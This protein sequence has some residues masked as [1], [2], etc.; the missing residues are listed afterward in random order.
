MRRKAD[1][2]EVLRVAPVSVVFQHH[3]K[4][5]E[6]PRP[7]DRVVLAVRFLDGDRVGGTETVVVRG[8][9]QTTEVLGFVRHVEVQQVLEAQTD[10]RVPGGV[11]QSGAV[12]TAP[13]RR[14][15]GVRWFEAVEAKRPADV[16][17]DIQRVEHVDAVRRDLDLVGRF[18]VV[19]GLF[20]VQSGPFG[21]VDHLALL[22][23]DPEDRLDTVV[24][25]GLRSGIEVGP[26]QRVTGVLAGGVRA[27]LDSHAF[28]GPAAGLQ[29]VTDD[30]QHVVDR[31]LVGPGHLDEQVTG[32]LAD[33]RP[34]AVDHRRER[35]QPDGVVDRGDAIEVG[36]Q[37]PVGLARLVVGDDLVGCHLLVGIERDERRLVRIDARVGDRLAGSFGGGRAFE[38]R[39]VVDTDGALGTL[40]SHRRVEFLLDLDQ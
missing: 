28:D 35:E 20:G 40:S 19:T 22:Q 7:E 32:V 26:L 4:R 23:G 34:A 25:D 3:H 1:L 30:V 36:H 9:V 17:D 18:T 31:P 15:V 6:R 38:H 33:L 12:V 39:Q 11:L 37:V 27:V 2:R 24:G 8:D 10:E 14:D 21:V 13:D 5:G 29:R 16:V